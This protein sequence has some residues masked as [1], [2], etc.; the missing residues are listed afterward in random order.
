MSFCYSRIVQNNPYAGGANQ[1]GGARLL[2]NPLNVP[3]QLVQRPTVMQLSGDGANRCCSMGG[4]S[5]YRG[6][7]Y[8]PSA[9]AKIPPSAGSPSPNGGYNNQ[10]A[11]RVDHLYQENNAMNSQLNYMAT[12]LGAIAGAMGLSLPQQESL[13]RGI[14]I[15]HGIT[16][17][18]PSGG[19]RPA[20][21]SFTIMPQQ[22]HQLPPTTQQVH[23]LLPTAPPQTPWGQSTD[24]MAPPD[25]AAAGTSTFAELMAP[26]HTAGRET[27]RMPRLEE[28]A[29]LALPE[30]GE[31]EPPPI[32]DSDDDDEVLKVSE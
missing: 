27:P 4:P 24:N 17:I 5:L 32:A 7:R 14:P 2:T 18:P 19:R 26:P 20:Q 9:M 16:M 15:G 21:G 10:L 13:D 12:A 1:N 28:A 6:S 22:T 11:S 30:E 23:E 3:Q 8:A 25:T 31:E 29:P